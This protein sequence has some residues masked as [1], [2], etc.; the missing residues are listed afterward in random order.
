M[1]IPAY[2]YRHWRHLLSSRKILAS[3][4]KE[5]IRVLVTVTSRWIHLGSLSVGL[6]INNCLIKLT[7][8]PE[9]LP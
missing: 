3:S 7:I 6:R 1:D 9:L 2:D 5:V 8:C 4:I